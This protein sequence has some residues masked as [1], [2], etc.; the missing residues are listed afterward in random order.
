MRN[1]ALHV[2]LVV[3]E[4]STVELTVAEHVQLDRLTRSGR[5]YV[6]ERH[7]GLLDRGMATLSLD[8]GYYFFQTLSGAHLRVIRGG[9]TT[10]V[11]ANIN[12][13]GPTPPPAPASDPPPQP[14]ASDEEQIVLDLARAD[15]RATGD[16]QLVLARQPPGKTP[17]SSN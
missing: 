4:P 12:P 11:V 2:T 9:V 16:R 5:G 10:A 7:G 17:K 3:R 13:E 8:P 1:R 14:D 6:A 15:V